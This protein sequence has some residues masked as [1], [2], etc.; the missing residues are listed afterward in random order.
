[1]FLFFLSLTILFPT[2]IYLL[3]NGLSLYPADLSGPLI[4]IP[5]TFLG[6]SLS[7]IFFLYRRASSSEMSRLEDELKWANLII[8]NTDEIIIVL[9]QYAQI[10][11]FN[12]VFSN[13]LDYSLEELKGKP[14]REIIHN[15]RID[16]NS[17]FNEILLA[18][19]KTVFS[20]SETELVCS[21]KK[22]HED[23]IIIISLRMIPIKSKNDLDTILIIGRPLQSDYLTRNYLI[24]ESSTYTIDNNLSQIF[25]LCHR[26]TRNLDGKMSKSE[27]MLAQIALQE[28]FVN[29]I[30]HG[31]LEINYERKT[32]LK[33]RKGNYWEMLV[34]E[35]NQDHFIKRKI[36]VYYELDDE[37]ALYIIRD[38]GRGFEWNRFISADENSISNEMLFSYHGVGLQIVK[39]I[40]DVNFNEKGNEVRLVKYFTGSVE[41]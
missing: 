20:G 15:E 14:L 34:N 33:K 23:E 28:V 22:N 21:F 16:N 29:A 38:E 7:L 10:I 6:L 12:R 24:H 4:F 8:S 37:K 31:N 41:A 2:L 32:E 17:R 5:L 39:R 1:M 36:H 3:R 25:L 30:E 18:K 13:L 40:F 19:L 9:N 27:I 11:S 26:L 35:C